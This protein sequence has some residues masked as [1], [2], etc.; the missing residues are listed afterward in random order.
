ML[1]LGKEFSSVASIP[2][3]SRYSLASEEGK[4]YVQA[5][6]IKK[7]EKEELKASEQQELDSSDEEDNVLQG[8]E[9][10]EEA[11]QEIQ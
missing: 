11:K 9:A 6:M 10:K 2:E 7:F 1:G 8:A 3:P 4:E 5:Q